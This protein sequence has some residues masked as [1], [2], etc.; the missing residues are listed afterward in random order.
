MKLKPFIVIFIIV[1]SEL[2]LLFYGGNL[3]ANLWLIPVCVI[4]F[5]IFGLSTFLVAKNDYQESKMSKKSAKR[6]KGFNR[7]WVFVGLV[8]VMVIMYFAIKF[9]VY[10]A[11]FLGVMLGLGIFLFIRVKRFR[12]FV[13]ARFHRKPKEIEPKP[14]K[15]Y[16][17]LSDKEELAILNRQIKTLNLKLRLMKLDK[18]IEQMSNGNAQAKTL[19][20][21]TPEEL[22]DALF[23]KQNVKINGGGH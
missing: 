22:A 21:A 7:G 15:N 6:N 20:N 23:K 8:T 9:W 12:E 1:F 14:N 2:T 4:I 19:E 10:V 18:N 16:E 13:K 5:V 11:I 17:H 3:N